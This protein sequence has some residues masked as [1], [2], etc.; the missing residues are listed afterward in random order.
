V[1]GGRLSLV[2]QGGAAKSQPGGIDLIAGAM[3]NYYAPSGGN[4]ELE[5]AT[6]ALL[7]LQQGMHI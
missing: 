2:P 7:Q 1:F 4:P 5:A 3:I 6:K